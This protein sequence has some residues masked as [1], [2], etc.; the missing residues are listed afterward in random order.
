MGEVEVRSLVKDF[1]GGVR[2]LDGLDLRIE[3]GEFFA[4]LG[5]SGCGKTTLLRSIA[6]ITD[7]HTVDEIA[8]L[9]A[10]LVADLDDSARV[11]ELLAGFVGAAPMRSTE[12]MFFAVRRLFEVLGT[13]QPVVLVV[14]DIQWAE[15]L[16]LDLLEHLAEWVQDVPLLVVGLARPEIREVRPA[17]TE[18]GRHVAA[19]INLDGLSDD[20]TIRFFVTVGAG[21]S[22]HM[23]L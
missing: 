4:L 13:N 7:A 17:I 15:A 1:G 16:F 22:H 10:T 12:E 11:A 2:A 20:A 14:D 18:P 9:V 5:P 3:D 8:T 21:L 23:R 19:V 6:G